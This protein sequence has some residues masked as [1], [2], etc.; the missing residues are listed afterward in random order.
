MAILET[1]MMEHTNPAEA[2]PGGSQA[3][4]E[5]DGH[6]RVRAARH[7]RAGFISA[8]RAL[9]C[10]R[11]ANRRTQRRAP[12]RGRTQGLRRDIRIQ[13]LFSSRSCADFC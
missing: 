1:R 3:A 8:T 4:E 7:T 9:E 6:V 5:G 12:K 13:F 11:Q 10:K 2:S